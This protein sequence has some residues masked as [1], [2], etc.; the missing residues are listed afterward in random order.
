MALNLDYSTL[1]G[2]ES[3]LRDTVRCRAFRRAIAEA[4]TPGCTVL[5]VGAGSGLL[6]MFAA[7]AGAKVVYAIEI[8]DIAK[9]AKAIVAKNGFSNR[10]Q[11]LQGDIAEVEIPEKVDIIVSEWLGSYGVDE[12]LLPV[13]I[14]A[15]DRWLK[16]GG[17]MIPTSVA[18]WMAPA[19]DEKLQQ[20]IDFWRSDPYDIDLDLISKARARHMDCFCNHVKQKHLL[21]APQL[22]WDIDCLNCSLEEAN[23]P[24][25][26]QL[27]FV[28]NQDGEINTLA[29]WF[30]AH[31]TKDVVLANGPGNPDTHWGRQVFPMGKA[32]SMKC[33]E[34]LGV[35]FTHEPCG[36]GHSRANW[37]IETGAYR[38]QSEGDTVLV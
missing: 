31:L 14:Q 29:A 6:S 38:F 24:F 11:I 19:F 30:H 20:E 27:D 32:V 13:V 16:P 2:Q 8:T 12:N 22:M 36:K 28:A 7:Q 5:D 9:V 21:S 37:T 17:K 23:N 25:H 26:T 15:R 3:M 4:V 34:R 33:G 35:D 10:I 18:A 1:S